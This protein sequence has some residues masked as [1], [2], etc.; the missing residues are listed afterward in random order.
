M[1]C[2]F[3]QP[4]QDTLQFSNRFQGLSLLLAEQLNCSLT[5]ADTVPRQC[6]KGA[7]CNGLLR[8]SPLVI[9]ARY[10]RADLTLI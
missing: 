8:I 5:S 6:G 7:L 1:T 3:E 4:R 9:D 2:T 10:I